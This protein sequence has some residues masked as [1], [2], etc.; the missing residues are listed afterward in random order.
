MYKNSRMIN[1]SKRASHRE[2]TNVY[3]YLSCSVF[4]DKSPRDP[5]LL[6][7]AAAIHRNLAEKKMFPK[8]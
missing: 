3:L 7:T 6:Q 5:P 8:P 2:E 1:I 4:M